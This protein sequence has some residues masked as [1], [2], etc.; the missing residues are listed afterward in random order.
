MTKM[1]TTKNTKDNLPAGWCLSTLG[2][3]C[4]RRGQYGT[5]KKSNGD[6]KGTPVLGMYNIHAYMMVVSGGRT[7][8]TLNYPDVNSQNTF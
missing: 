4:E 1:A 7:Y 6:E 8:L 5:S 2:D 3:L